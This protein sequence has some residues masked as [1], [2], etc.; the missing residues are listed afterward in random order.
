[1]FFLQRLELR[2]KR[3]H[4]HHLAA[5]AHRQGYE[6]SAYNQREGNDGNTEVQEE[7]AIQKH[8]TVYHRLDD[9]QVPYVDKNLK[10]LH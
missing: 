8:Q 4:L 3:C 6:D 1:V 10:N 2:L 9:K 5:L 7:D